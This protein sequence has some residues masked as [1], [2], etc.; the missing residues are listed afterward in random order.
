MREERLWRQTSFDLGANVWQVNWLYV[1]LLCALAGIGYVAL[2]SAAGGAPEPYAAR[3]VLRFGVAFVD[4]RA[5]RSEVAR[6]GEIALAGRRGD[7]VLVGHRQAP[8]KPRMIG[9][10]RG[11]AKML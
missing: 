1:A 2:F 6:D 5:W 9:T 7:D 8:T 10:I 4:Q 3:H 11:S